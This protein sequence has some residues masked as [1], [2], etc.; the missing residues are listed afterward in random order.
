MSFEAILGQAHAVRVLRGAL[1]S[2][3]VPHAYLFEGPPGVGKRLAARAL[4]L[5]LN[6]REGGADA[7]GACLDCRKIASD[8]H[9]D[10]RWLGLP[11]GKRRIPIEAVREHERWLALGPHE[12][13]AKLLV[14][15]PAEQLS[16][17]AANALLKTLEEPRPGSFVV[18]V[19]AAASALLPT[20]RSRCQRVRFA[21]LP[22]ETVERLLVAGGRAPEEARAL[23]ALSGGSLDRAAACA[24]ED[25]D[26]R[27]GRVLSLLEG[28][29]G[30]TP[31][32]GLDVSASLRGDRE[33]ATRVLELALFVLREILGRR[34][35]DAS[36]TGA[37]G[38]RQ[39]LGR[40]FDDLT[41]AGDV[42]DAARGIAAV[43]RALTAMQRNNMN[44]QLAVEAALTA[45]RGRRAG[46]AGWDRI[47]AGAR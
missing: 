34:A 27:L 37:A 14:I 28:A 47:G 46:G 38:L 19:T 3:K 43:N 5:A 17:A 2:G 42:T 9:P 23:A 21:A 18:L 35:G 16:E 22:A 41:A 25:L 13:R 31:G 26:A 32:P 8:N 10:V 6:C 29:V 15:E 39:R 30:T 7:C 44:P 40:R 20:V 45:M 12:G 36:A 4:A 11:E 33:E 24:G 1:A